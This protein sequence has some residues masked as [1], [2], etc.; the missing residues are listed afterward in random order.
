MFHI[1]EYT[2]HGITELTVTKEMVLNPKE[3]TFPK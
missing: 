3:I 1:S 2:E